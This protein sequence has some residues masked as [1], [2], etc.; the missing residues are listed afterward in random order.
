VLVEAMGCGNPV[1]S[2]DCDHG[3]AE[4]LDQ[5]RH[6]A[7][8]PPRNPQP[9]AAAMDM[10]ADL[11]KRWPSGLLTARAAEFSNANCAIAYIRLCQSPA[12]QRANRRAYDQDQQLVAER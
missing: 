9:L 4:I 2:T 6:G 1:I 8:V 10:V 11:R 5:G 12:A 3:P 7:L